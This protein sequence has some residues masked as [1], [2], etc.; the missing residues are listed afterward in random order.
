MEVG[1][2]TARAAAKDFYSQVLSHG[3]LIDAFHAMNKGVKSKQYEDIYFFWGLHIATIKPPAQRSDQKVF[4]A[5]VAALTLW[6]GHYHRTQDATTKRNC[7]PIL[8]FIAS[9]IENNF[10]PEHRAR[11]QS[12]IAAHLPEQ[13]RS[14]P[15]GEEPPDDERQRGVLDI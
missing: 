2:A 14:L 7:I 1:N 8:N 11:L 6:L 13:Y 4:N 9:E 10:T 15:T 3:R 12:E 5:L